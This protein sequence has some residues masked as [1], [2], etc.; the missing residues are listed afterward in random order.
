[1]RIGS[2]MEE[3]MSVRSSQ[4][5]DR[6]LS[7]VVENGNNYRIFA[8][9]VKQPSGKWTFIWPSDGGRRLDYD[10]FNS[11]WVSY[12]D[13]GLELLSNGH[14]TDATKLRSWANIARVIHEGAYNAAINKAKR[15]AA[16]EASDAG[17]QVD[18][19]A[20]QVKL[21]EIEAAYHG[22][23]VGKTRV[24]PT[25][26]PV[27][28]PINIAMTCQVFVVKF[29][30][31]KKE[32]DWDTAATATVA[33]SD[34]KA[35]ELMMGLSAANGFDP[36]FG[37]V[38]YRYSYIG[39]DK[40]AAGMKAKFEPIKRVEDRLM[41]IDPEGWEANK[42]IIFN[43]LS[44]NP[45]VVIAK[46]PNL[47]STITIDDVESKMKAYC[48]KSSAALTHLDLEDKE[49]IKSAAFMLDN[50]VLTKVPK[51]AAALRDIVKAN[52]VVPTSEKEE[53]SEVE[54][55][56]AEL[57]EKIKTSENLEEALQGMAEGVI[58]NG[59]DIAS[60][61]IEELQ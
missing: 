23:K 43:R 27:I 56:A 61:S 46:S 20:L 33:L 4:G 35:N 48:A 3:S 57:N 19:A 32:I 42:E 16:S 60:A 2:T 17:T 8:L 53:L 10:V 58:D 11:T 44:S 13:G 47:S 18:E 54:Q 1:M 28:G 59:E 50:D 34:T 21:Q 5:F 7:K 31:D 40:K 26:N 55:Q 25:L 14:Y 39:A 15:E 29:D 12:P 51:I 22:V 9:P 38:E 37:L 30:E 24:L 52:E 6:N 36:E 41:S 49:V 45:D